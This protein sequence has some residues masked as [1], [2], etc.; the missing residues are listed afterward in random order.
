MEC[1]I[2]DVRALELNTKTHSDNSS[3]GGIGWGWWSQWTAEL[4]SVRQGMWVAWYSQYNQVGWSLI[5][6]MLF[7]VLLCVDKVTRF[8]VTLT[9]VSIHVFEVCGHITLRVAFWRTHYCGPKSASIPCRSHSSC[10]CN[11]IPWMMFF[12]MLNVHD[13]LQDS[14][15]FSG[16]GR[17]CCL[18]EHA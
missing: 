3:S 7:S 5:W 2:S 8:I 4:G 15:T 17:H 13:A 16:E 1:G 18:N 10:L 12:T 6:G 9:Y 11:T 14:T